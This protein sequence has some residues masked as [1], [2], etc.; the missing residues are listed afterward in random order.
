MRC[1]FVLSTLAVALPV[2]G[3][4]TDSDNDLEALLAEMWE[5]RMQQWPQWATSVGDHRFNDR[6]AKI[7]LQDAQRRNEADR[8]FLSRLESIERDRLGAKA[9]V[10]YDLMRRRL[11]ESLA[12]FDFE[13]HLTP[14]SNRSGFHIEFPDMRLDMPFSVT[15]D[16]E[17]YIDRLGAF[18]DYVD[19]HIELMR[20]GIEA[21][22][23]LPG[24]ILKGFEPSVDAHVVDDPAQSLFYEP[25]E[26]FPPSVGKDDR[27]RLR[28]AA[29]Q[30]I[31][32]VVVPGYQ[33][34]GAF[35]R[36]EYLPN[37][38][39]SIGASALPR[40][41]DFYRHR[42]RKYTTLEQTPEEVHARGLAE[43]GRIRGEMDEII[44]RVDF[45]GDFADFVEFLRTDPQFYA[46]T[47]EQ[48]LQTA[49]LILKRAD[50]KLPEMFGRLPR[51]PYGLREIP[52]YIAPRTTSAYYMRPTGDGSRAGFFYLNTYNLSS[53][54]L[55]ALEALSLHEAVPGHHLQLALQ[56]EMTDLPAFRKY[57]NYTAFIEG[58]ALYAER[59]G[60]E[61]GFYEDP[62]SDFGRLTMEIWRACRLV[63][64]TGIH[65]L[66]WTRQQAIEYMT[67]NSALSTHN[68]QA[69]IDRYIGWPGQA[70]AYKTGELKIRELRAL[71][72]QRL[73]EAFDVRA[74]HDVVLEGG[75]VP[76]DVLDGAVCAWID[77][78]AK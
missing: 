2:L 54:P 52:A 62:Y 48:L 64:D 59:L 55:Y 63:V 22:K 65:Y 34:F 5:F 58:W 40:G 47:E 67:E 13:S 66:G 74:F 9:Q 49:G 27:Q 18:G 75:A 30:V 71:A 26:K 31:R 16:Y 7:S 51:M 35:L 70:L 39:G 10:N 17:N 25:F 57:S 12:E 15:R 4:E 46:Q 1:V 73:A 24:V 8:E 78:Q 41:R 20:A 29:Q 11:R 53:R 69:E 23:T 42:V 38:R 6:L 56:Q 50:G 36:D 14:I 37:C 76:L 43:V 3:V 28:T 32:D 21:E 19:G 44:R 45:D 61:M 72:E 33:R 68:I 60:L 77:Q